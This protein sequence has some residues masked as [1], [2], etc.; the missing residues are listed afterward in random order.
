MKYQSG[1]IVIANI[2]N[3]QKIAYIISHRM[4][5]KYDDYKVIVCGI[6][7]EYMWVFEVHIVGKIESK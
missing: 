4:W 1:D 7:N 2:S 5:D 3:E 6:P